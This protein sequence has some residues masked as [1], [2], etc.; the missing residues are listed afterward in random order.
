[1]CT[2]CRESEMPP[3]DAQ[4]MDYIPWKVKLQMTWEVIRLFWNDLRWELSMIWRG[5]ES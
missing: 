1:M 5:F 2:L 3:F 4:E